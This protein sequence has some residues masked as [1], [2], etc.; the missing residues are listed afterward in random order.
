[1][2]VLF[3]LTG[4]GK[5]TVYKYLVNVIKNVRKRLSEEDFEMKEWLLSDQTFEKMGEL[6]CQNDGKMLGLYDE[7]TNWLS[8]VNLYS[9]NK[10]LLDTHEFTKVLELLSA[11]AWSR[12]TGEPINIIYYFFYK[13]FMFSKY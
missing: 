8:Q 6:M 13:Q 3:T 1:M 9:G 7:L 5:S 4:T 11:T 2:Y 12:Q 10:G